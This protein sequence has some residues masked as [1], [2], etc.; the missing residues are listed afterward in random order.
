MVYPAKKDWW[1]ACLILPAGLGLL[2]GTVVAVS[3]AAAGA[4]PPQAWLLALLPAVVGLL[5]LWMFLGTSYEIGESDLV[6]RLGPFRWRVPLGA[7]E[8]VVAT[9]G[10]RLVF[11]TGL[12]WSLNMLHVRYR[13]GSGRTAVVSISPQDKDEFIRELAGVVPGLKVRTA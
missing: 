1:V 3:Q 8:E 9:T 4:V 13:K 10:F 5:L 11:G 2:G 6:A 12:A 7:I